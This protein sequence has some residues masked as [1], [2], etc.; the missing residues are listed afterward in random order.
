MDEL[1]ILE[2][3][4]I[5]AVVLIVLGAYLLLRSIPDANREVTQERAAMYYWHK[6]GLNVEYMYLSDG[7]QMYAV[8][9]RNGNML[10]LCKWLEIDKEILDYYGRLPEDFKVNYKGKVVLR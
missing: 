6:N 9:D 1:Y 5:A 2:I 10:F 3:L 7:H 4:I 8:K